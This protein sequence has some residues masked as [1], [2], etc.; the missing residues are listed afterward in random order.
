MKMLHLI[1][2]F[3]YSFANLPV[4]HNLLFYLIFVSLF[5]QKKL[6]PQVKQDKIIIEGAREN[7]LKN[8]SLSIP[9]NKITV[10][11]GVS[12]SGKSSLV[13]DTLFAEGQRRYVESLSSYARQF[14]GKLK[15]PDVE[16]ITGIPPA[17]AIEQKTIQGNNRST[18]GTITEIYDYLQ[19]LFAKI[20]RTYSPVS[21][22][23]VKKHTTEDVVDFLK[24]LEENTKI[25]IEIPI[26][27]VTFSDI[28][29]EI[30]K[31]SQK[32][33]IRLS[34]K[35]K[36]IFIS[37][38]EKN[39]GICQKET[40]AILVDRIKIKKDNATF[41]RLYESV[42]I[43]FKEV[44]ECQI[45][46]WTNNE[47]KTKLFNNRFEADGITFIEPSYH[48]F[49]F[50]NP[51]GACP[52]CQGYG[53]IIDYSED[54]VFPDKNL[55]V[56]E[57]GIAPWRG[58]KSKKYKEQLIKN[59]HKF[60]FPIYK[61]IKDLTCKQLDLLWQGNK[62]FT[63]LRDFFKM[64]EA[65]IYKV[66]A[67]VF[68]SRFRSQTV[69]PAC[70][71]GRLRKETAYV[72]IGGKN[73]QELIE[74]E[75]EDLFLFFKNLNLTENEYNI[76]KHIL[77][78]I[79]KRLDLLLKVGL[80]Y[81]TLN[82]TT[83]TLS[84]GEA[85][86]IRLANSIGSSLMGTLYIL[87]EPSIGLHHSDT[88]KLIKVLK[89]L[90]DIGN[91]VVVVEH[92][93]QIIREADY[94]IDLGPLA[95]INGGKIMFSDI[96]DKL[97][98]YNTLTA[99]YLY[100]KRKIKVPTTRRPWSN[101][102]SLTGATEHNLKLEHHTVKFPLNVITVITGVSGS[103]KSSL[104]NDIL[105][106][107]LK[108]VINE[109]NKPTGNFKQIDGDLHLIKHVELVD[110]KPIGKSS[111]SNPVTYIKAYDEVRKL[112]ASQH[113]A[114]FNGFT[115]AY[116]SFN[117]DGGRC[118]NCKG[119]GVIKI[120]MQFMADVYLTCDVCGGKRFKEEVLEVTYRGE[121]IADI[122]EMTIDEAIDF[123]SKDN[124]NLA[125]SI[126][127]KLSY[128]QEV[129]LGYLQLGQ[130]SVTLSGGESQRIKL[131]YFLSKEKKEHTLFLFDEPTTGLHFY[132]IEKLLIAFDK[133]IKRG[134]TIIVIEHN[135]EIIKYADW[136]I[137]L[138]PGGGKHGGKI[139]VEGTPEKVSKCEKSFTGKMLKQYLE[140]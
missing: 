33:F 85:Q 45:K 136:I 30:N 127:K 74:M 43:A 55:S 107:A 123:F 62:Y 134:N 125:Q 60:N 135:P 34:C 129:G 11:T 22:T 17:V 38:F 10:V 23:E 52:V 78:E 25:F 121:N 14:L 133:L 20:G 65:K 103:G 67:R 79:T 48:F 122:L 37:D 100:G 13:F 118:E 139:V 98:N 40:I 36:A 84:G 126:K 119:E 28:A 27:K 47:I 39:P 137:D 75:L 132:D 26:K 94:L 138:G 16:K 53:N 87:D 81:L 99:Q 90:R 101:Y 31:Y 130:S 29:E 66:Q 120:D 77:Y 88:D 15:K 102:I 124:N 76:A 21:G 56:Y 58:E 61:P 51:L 3:T 69:C 111:R 80:G 95:G 72:K 24:T 46:Y 112:F 64:I 131:A 73:I 114:K 6:F 42:E 44:G 19:L 128:L 97:K 18:V 110:Q 93:E 35:N 59:A 4:N 113:K 50:N 70:H 1:V 86:R 82:R 71:G 109:E 96:P 89:Q 108:N 54:L 91:T 140:H 92:D 68:I 104:M 115:P 49:S 8:I 117:V 83:N 32:G 106:K 63:G 7:N 9:R 116:F 2:E 12:G 41:S 57:D 105:Y 5:F